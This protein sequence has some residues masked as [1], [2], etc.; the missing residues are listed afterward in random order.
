MRFGA[1]IALIVMALCYVALAGAQSRNDLAAR[2]AQ[3]QGY[4]IDSSDL[5]W[6]E[7]DNG[8]NVSWKKAIQYCHDL[9]L[10][11]YSDWRLATVDEMRG[12]YDK[13]I[14]APGLAGSKKSERAFTWHV[15]GN[16]FLTGDQWTSDYRLDDRGKPSGY[17]WYFDFNEGRA[18]NEPTGWPYS[19]SGM[20]ALCVRR[21]GK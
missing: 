3:A 9:R 8:R 4:W 12:I 2:E 19:Y 5:M 18:D 6:A 10:A 14:E 13:T 7:R 17:A 21:A 11:G 20:R 15:K 16:L 1:K